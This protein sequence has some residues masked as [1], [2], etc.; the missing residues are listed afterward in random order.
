MLAVKV[1]FSA[2]FLNPNINILKADSSDSIYL[3]YNMPVLSCSKS[4]F[5]G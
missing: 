4:W 1:M 2:W 5:C 3:T